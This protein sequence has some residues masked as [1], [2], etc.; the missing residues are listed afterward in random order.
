MSS[1]CY[2]GKYPPQQGGTAV[3][4][5]WLCHALAQRGYAVDVVSTGGYGGAQYACAIG[6]DDWAALHKSY[7][8]FSAVRRIDIDHEDRSRS[9]AI[10]DVDPLVSRLASAA[11]DAI[12]EHGAEFIV[13]H[14]L[15]P[16]GV[17]AALVA[18]LT[19][20]P[21]AI[22][23][24][25]SDI[26]RLSRLPTRTSLYAGVLAR[27][28]IVLSTRAAGRE[29]QRLGARPEAIIADRPSL[30]PLELFAQPAEG[31]NVAALRRHL[32]DGRSPWKVMGGGLPQD[33]PV[34][35]IFGK[36][37]DAKGS[38]DIARALGT[39]KR[40]GRETPHLLYVTEQ[41]S[42]RFDHLRSL[43][44]D[45]GVLDDV[46][47]LPYLPHW[48]M[49]GAFALCSVVAFLENRF[50]VEIHRPQVPREA[51]VSGKCVLLSSE[52]AGYQVTTR[53]ITDQQDALIVRDPRDI[54]ELSAALSRIAR[55]P[56][57]ISEIGEVARSLYRWPTN[58]HVARWIDDFV[59]TMTSARH[60]QSG[61]DMT[62]AAFQSTLV[63][64]YADRTFRLSAREALPAD[65]SGQLTD[66]E[67]ASIRAVLADGQ[68]LERYCA[69][70]I[71]K[72]YSF[73]ARHFSAVLTAYPD[74]EPA[75]RAAFTQEWV[76]R[77]KPLPDELEQFEGLL[78]R[79]AER[80][81]DGAVGQR[82][83]A[84]IMLAGARARA[85]FRPVR[86]L[87]APDPADETSIVRLAPW[88]ELLNLP[89]VPEGVAAGD[90]GTAGWHG[91]VV[92]SLT[93]FGVRSFGISEIMYRVLDG[94]R[95]P[96]TIG[97]I[98]AELLEA[99]AAQSHSDVL[100]AIR[101]LASIG[102]I[103]IKS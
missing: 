45:E 68:A 75:L 76:L 95:N 28:S 46:T 101:G 50:S 6:E 21:Y 83:L 47:L 27:A 54:A 87:V 22:I 2:L 52:V 80:S 4:G 91:L 48:R 14:Y 70:L 37:G 25:G 26:A 97:A 58:G 73:L 67:L 16:Y 40:S 24:A 57:E 39:L 59:A 71:N 94:L 96:N 12:A 31:L 23:H 81:L 100:E 65:T 64:I 29:I 60:V 11:L 38:F 49:P 44:A 86:E 19:R 43:L 17:A 35:G 5:L 56:A 85:L 10:P 42:R 69:S 53:P 30:T 9:F 79:I 78:L 89:T 77:E 55:S 90:P 18:S 51:A 88:C 15:E 102:A 3:Q 33:R 103:E 66:R 61:S 84:S 41:E 74:L 98:V 34:V 99:D 62:L 1:V 93:D 92:P 63:R 13:G 36:L 32:A 72:K 20:L 8:A 7:P 82:P